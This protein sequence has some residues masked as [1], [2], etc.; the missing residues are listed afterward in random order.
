MQGEVELSQEEKRQA[1]Q[2][3]RNHC[4][5]CPA[6]ATVSDFPRVLFI[7][8]SYPSSQP[9]RLEWEHCPL[10]PDAHPLSRASCPSTLVHSLCPSPRVGGGWRWGAPVTWHRASEHCVDQKSFSGKTRFQF[11]K[12]NLTQRKTKQPNSQWPQKDLPTPGRW[13][14]LTPPGSSPS[15]PESPLSPY[16]SIMGSRAWQGVLG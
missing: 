6:G 4:A 14:N 3:K 12:M 11:W 8:C 7:C 1:P 13:R 5:G 2:S 16:H 10:H 9:L 15:L